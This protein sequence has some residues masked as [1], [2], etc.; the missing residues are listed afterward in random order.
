MAKHRLISLERPRDDAANMI[1]PASALTGDSPLPNVGWGMQIRFEG[2]DLD[3][4]GV[5]LDDEVKK[6]DVLVIKA[7]IMVTGFNMR[8][9]LGQPDSECLEASIIAMR[10]IEN[11]GD[12]DD[13]DEDGGK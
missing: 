5:D 6:G 10:I 4:L 9:Q 8:Q 7:R 13:D 12:D 2:P 11:E 3:R 1:A